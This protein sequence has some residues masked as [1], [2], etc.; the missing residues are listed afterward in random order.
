MNKN[1]II[2]IIVPVY[3]AEIYLN[4]CIC[5]IL[6]Q[7]YRNFELILVDDGSIDKSLDICNKFAKCDNRIKIIHQDNGGVSAA[8]NRGIKEAIGE[9]IVFVDA[10]DYVKDNYIQTLIEYQ[11]KYET[12]FIC[13]S[14][15]MEKKF[16]RKKCKIYSEQYFDKELFTSKFLDSFK[17]IANAPWG[18]LFSRKIIIENSILFP[19]G[20]PYAEDSIFCIEYLKYID[21]AMVISEVIY[22]YN[23]TD[24]NIAMRKYYK[25]ICNYLYTVLQKKEELYNKRGLLLEFENLKI[26]EQQYYLWKNI[27]I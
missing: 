5:S 24:G 19:E 7:K 6:N 25:D 15:C 2:S 18:K 8:R 9:F 11:Q 16:G 27:Q 10:D 22:H 20:I 1:M 17:H 13:G 26:K 12:K 23:C 14:Y 21:S 3:N 4:R